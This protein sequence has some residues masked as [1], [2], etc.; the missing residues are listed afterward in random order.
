MTGR[1][2]P[3]ADVFST[4]HHST[5]GISTEVILSRPIVSFAQKKQKKVNKD[6]G[7]GVIS[8]FALLV[9][10]RAR[11]QI[12]WS[13]LSGVRSW[14]RTNT[15]SGSHTHTHTHTRTHKK[16]LLQKDFN[17]SLSSRLPPAH[18]QGQKEM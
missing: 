8:P 7:R 5:P 4:F 12:S 10:T 6:G 13:A 18:S 2:G 15:L 14:T 16:I 17:A 9:W 11:S 1:T 3:R